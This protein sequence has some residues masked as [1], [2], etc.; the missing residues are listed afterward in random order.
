MSVSPAHLRH[1]LDG[2]DPHPYDGS[3]ETVDLRLRTGR[4]P[5]MCGRRLVRSV[6]KR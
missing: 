5:L 4:M 2:D 3:N 6:F 1:L